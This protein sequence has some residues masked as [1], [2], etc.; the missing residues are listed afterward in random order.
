MA[1]LTHQQLRSFY[2]TLATVAA[3]LRHRWL[4]KAEAG[5][6]LDLAEELKRFTVDVTTLLVLGHDVDTIGQDDDVIQRE[7]EVMFPVITRRLFALLPAGRWLRTPADRRLERALVELRAWLDGLISAARSRVEAEPERAARPANFLDSMVAARDTEGRPFPDDVIF[8]NLITMLLAGED[9]TAYTLGWAVHHLCDAPEAVARVRAEADVVL[10]DG[11]VPR[12]IETADRLAYI[13][14]QRGDA[15]P[16][17][18]AADRPGGQTRT[19]WS[20]MLRY[21]RRRSSPSLPASACSTPTASRTRAPSA[22]NGGCRGARQ[23]TPT[24]RQR[25]CRSARVH[26]SAPDARLRCLR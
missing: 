18:G 15:A 4:Q 3:R 6:E 21:P 12:S 9:T 25:T 23:V 24:T 2:P 22:P 20:A 17:R 7:L 1:A 26:A 19:S 14:R 13:R 11:C 5:T 8:G 10:D 16:S